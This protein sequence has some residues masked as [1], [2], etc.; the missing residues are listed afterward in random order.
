MSSRESTPVRLPGLKQ[1]IGGTWYKQTQ[2]EQASYRMT[3]SM[4]FGALLGA[5]L[6]T[7]SDLPV[8]DYVSVIALLI[9]WVMALQLVSVARSRIYAGVT[10]SIYGATLLA[11]YAM[12][13]LR[14]AG[15][16]EADFAKLA[17]TLAMWLVLVAIVELTPTIGEEER[18]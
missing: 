8:S 11:A 14:P 9:G 18:R 16:S 12:G 3:T 1:L 4:F 17:A 2:R 5:N 13:Q 10:L 15:L 7:L 6:G